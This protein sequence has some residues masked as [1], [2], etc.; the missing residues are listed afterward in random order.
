VYDLSLNRLF[1]QGRQEALEYDLPWSCGQNHPREPQSPAL[2][3]SD[4]VRPL[5][6][7]LDEVAEAAATSLPS[8]APLPAAEERPQEITGGA[9]TNHRQLSR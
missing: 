9:T 5:W 1:V 8:E 7:V 2:P 6:L 3:R 4:L